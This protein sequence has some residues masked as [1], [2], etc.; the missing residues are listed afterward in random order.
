[1]KLALAYDQELGNSQALQ[2]CLKFGGS[3]GAAVAGREKQ[4]ESTPGQR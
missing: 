4:S 3:P 2:S 1:M